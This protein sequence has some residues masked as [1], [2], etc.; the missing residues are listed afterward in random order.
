MPGR[1][2]TGPLGQG[3]VGGGRAGMGRGGRGRMGVKYGCRS[4]RILCVSEV[5]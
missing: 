3:P 4:G 2:G 1:D 5:R